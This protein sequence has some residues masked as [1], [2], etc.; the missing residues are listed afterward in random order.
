M[1]VLGAMV[2]GFWILV[3]VSWVVNLVKLTECDFESDYK[4]EA[5]HVI[6][7]VP[8]ISLGAAWVGSDEDE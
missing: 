5:L 2:I 7:L 4:C 6:G 3:G 1:K 8:F